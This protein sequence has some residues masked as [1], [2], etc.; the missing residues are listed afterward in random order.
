MH[1]TV[2]EDGFINLGKIPEEEF[3]SLLVSPDPDQAIL[4]W[5]ENN[6]DHDVAVCY[7]C[8]DGEDWYGEPGIHD[9]SDYGPDGPYASNGGLP[10][11][12]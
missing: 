11:C 9:R 5:I 1:C 7:C 10:L 2:C 4:D 8:G 6:D 12:S 3:N